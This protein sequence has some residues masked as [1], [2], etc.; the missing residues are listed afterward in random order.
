MGASSPMNTWAS[1][2]SYGTP[3]A[4]DAATALSCGWSYL[5]VPGKIHRSHWRRVSNLHVLQPAAYR[6]FFQISSL[7]FCQSAAL[8]H[9]KPP[10]PHLFWRKGA[11]VFIGD[12]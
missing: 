4:L 7:L 10:R 6:H 8:E 2:I 9:S 5:C 12:A 3:S 1:S 11:N